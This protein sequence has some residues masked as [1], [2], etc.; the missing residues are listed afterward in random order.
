[1]LFFFSAEIKRVDENAT[2]IVSCPALAGN[3][4]PSISLYK[5]DI[6]LHST[7]MSDVDSNQG[8]GF[9]VYVQNSSV[10]YKIQR[11]EASDTGLYSCKIDTQI[12]TSA[13]QTILLI[14]GKT[15]SNSF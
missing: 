15:R 8:Q 14:K 7:N 11:V 9:Q 1:M 13:S 4:K 10:S 12:K 6:K 3:E 5:G 2:A